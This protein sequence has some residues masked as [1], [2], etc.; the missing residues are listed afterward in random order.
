MGL[1]FDSDFPVFLYPTLIDHL[2]YTKYT[3]SERH[4]DEEYLKQVQHPPSRG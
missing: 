1:I 3:L 2:S 4:F